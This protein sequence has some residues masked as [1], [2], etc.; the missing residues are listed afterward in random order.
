MEI[1]IEYFKQ[2]PL[3]V[4]IILQIPLI[5]ILLYAVRLMYKEIK[6]KEQDNKKSADEHKEELS[7]LNITGR[8]RELDNYNTLKDLI[9]LLEDIET[10]QKIIISKLDQR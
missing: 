6:S 1:L 10:N 3:P 2:Y 5:L 8:K 9:V 7:E 4:L